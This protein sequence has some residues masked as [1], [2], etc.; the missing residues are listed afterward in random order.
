[1]D[2]SAEAV[3]FV[4]AT[5]SARLD[6]VLDVILL[7]SKEVLATLKGCRSHASSVL[8]LTHGVCINYGPF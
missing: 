3:Y 4:E 8:F 5:S 1:M 6:E 2:S 7:V